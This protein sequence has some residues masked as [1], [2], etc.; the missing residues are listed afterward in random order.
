MSET[1]NLYKICVQCNGTGVAP[2]QIGNMLG[3]GIDPCPWPG[4]NGD[5]YV[6]Y[7]KFDITD[8]ADT[9]NDIL[10]KVNDIKQIMNEL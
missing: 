2:N 10:D 9:I 4:C 5:G 3:P 7:G 1:V 6:E 8:L